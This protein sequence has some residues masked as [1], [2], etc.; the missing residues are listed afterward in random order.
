MIEKYYKDDT[1]KYKMILMIDV[2]VST[3]AMEK[4]LPK[5]I[6]IWADHYLEPI[7]GSTQK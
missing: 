1:Y 4:N 3:Q 6:V 2:V 7:K 5:K